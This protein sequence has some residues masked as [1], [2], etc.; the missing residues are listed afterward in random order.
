MNKKAWIWVG[1][2]VVLGAGVSLL[3]NTK[4]VPEEVVPQQV[5]QETE[6]AVDQPSEVATEEPVV[7]EE[8][9][10][11]PA[12]VSEAVQTLIDPESGYKTRLE[13][14]RQLGYE[15]SQQDIATLVEFMREPMPADAKL[16]PASYNSIRNDAFEILMRQ[17]QMPEGLGE[18]LTDVFNDPEH[19]PMWRNYC[20]QFMEPYYEKESEVLSAQSDGTADSSTNATPPQLKSIEDTLWSAV[21]ERDNSNAGTALLA[22]DKLSR[23]HSEFGKE[24]LNS[25]MVELA[26]D[27]QASVANRVTALRLCGERS[28][29][30]ALE[31]ARNLARQCDTTMIRCAAIATLGDIGTEEDLELIEECSLSEDKRIARI[32]KLSMEKLTPQ[33]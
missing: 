22:M 25:A 33:P 3:L 2:V 32:A 14:M 21:D 4:K 6:T 16:N 24:Q 10:D 30:E 29:M 7:Q 1:L 8:P 15:L 11:Q 23:S 17:K 28:N 31:T 20:L 27:E 12:M 19:D 26:S 5:Q 13:A 9:T 18:L